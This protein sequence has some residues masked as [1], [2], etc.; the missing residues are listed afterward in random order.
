MRRAQRRTLRV[1]TVLPDIPLPADTGLHLRMVGNLA[2]VRALGA[3]SSALCFSTEE[4]SQSVELL[5][6]VN[7]LADNVTYAGQ[8]KPQRSFTR[9][10][11][12]SA[13]LG[14]M[15]N[16]ILG[17]PAN[18]Y[19]F[20]M[21]YDAVGGMQLAVEEAKRVRADFVIIPSIFL[22][23]APALRATG[24][25][26]IADAADVLSDV[27][28]RVADCKRWM[29]L[30]SRLSL[31]A[32]WLASRT[33]ERR[34]FPHCAEVW[35]TSEAEARRVEALVPETRVVVMPNT[36]AVDPLREA[37]P[38]KPV[39][40]GFIGTYSYLPNL[41]AA[42]TLVRDIFP[43]VRREVPGA[44]LWLAGTRL[45]EEFANEFAAQPDI[46]ALGRVEDSAQ[47]LSSCSVVALPV[48]VR[49]G[50]PLKL[51][52]AM[53]LS[54][55]VVASP[56]LVEGVSVKH[57]VDLLIG[58]SNQDFVRQLVSVLEDDLLANRLGVAARATYEG[59]FSP[60]AL[61]RNAQVSS[62]LAHE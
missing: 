13:K 19:P 35:V 55:A 51:I 62:L 16:G 54:K 22:H 45:P 17:R 47:F 34:Y 39:S 33:Q 20:S 15:G 23:W 31:E 21:R 12:L 2:V 10:E 49:G 27:T 56:Q 26:V 4:R 29:N 40:I 59:C 42:R 6:E 44:T 60:A 1:L 53:A 46:T 32:N 5:D 18:S 28:R 38:M 37:V 7:D 52:E 11:Q 24:A 48:A 36:V 58:G 41:D 43:L 30:L 14:F 3:K 25:Q 8:R 61:L 50:V 57:D 9:R